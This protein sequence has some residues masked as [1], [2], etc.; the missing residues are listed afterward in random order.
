[1]KIELVDLRGLK[2]TCELIT[3]FILVICSTSENILYSLRG[4]DK[5]KILQYMCTIVSLIIYEYNRVYIYNL[6]LFPP[7]D[8]HACMDK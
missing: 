3:L 5:R 8:A 6:V 4:K 1:M 7:L 2:Y